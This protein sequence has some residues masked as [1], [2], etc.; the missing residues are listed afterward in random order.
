MTV[1][2]SETELYF[3]EDMLQEIQAEAARQDRS[4]R[5]SCRGLKIARKDIMK[6]RAS[7]RTRTRGMSGEGRVAQGRRRTARR[8]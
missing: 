6:F 4:C 7:R 1:R 8:L 2:T 3:Q 5:G